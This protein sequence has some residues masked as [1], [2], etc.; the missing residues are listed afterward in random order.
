MDPP[1]VALPLL[2]QC[3]VTGPFVTSMSSSRRD[4]VPPSAPDSTYVP[5][6]G[7]AGSVCWTW[8]DALIETDT[9]RLPSTMSTSCEPFTEPLADAL[10]PPHRPV[11]SESE[12]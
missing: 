7:G 9:E 3:S 4:C 8:N 1:L 10:A 6:M 12:T 11:D 5:V 2:S